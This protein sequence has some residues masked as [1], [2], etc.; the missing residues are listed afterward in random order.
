[1][2]TTYSALRI[3][4]KGSIEELHIEQL[5]FPEPQ[6]GFVLIKVECSTINPSD[7]LNILGHYPGGE[8]PLTPGL[9]GSGTVVKS[10]GGALADSLLNKRVTFIAP[11]SWAEYTITSATSVFPL[12]DSITFEQGASLNINP[13]TVAL[14]IE[15]VKQ[16]PSKAF[17]QNAASS[18]LAKQFIRWS[19]RLG[20]TSIN[21]VRR[22]EQVDLLKSFGAEHVFNTSEEGW[23]AK[24]KEI[25][26][27]FG[28]TIGFDAIGGKDTQ[29]LADV[30]GYKGVV[31]NYGL[32]SGKSCEMG[33]ASLQFQDKRLKGLW[34]SA[35]FK[36]TEYEKKLEASMSVQQNIDVLSTEYG[37]TVSLG[38][39]KTALA[40]YL[41][42]A[43]N[44][45]V[46]IRA[47]VE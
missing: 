3:N 6:E 14:F 28:V 11:G 12:L 32:L 23:K 31:Y 8:V 42:N 39:V 19:Q 20:I 26:T 17:V 27:Q 46:L 41:Q 4:Q 1:M 34:L 40:S 33:P 21:L 43:T 7:Y 10:G 47:I 30:L 5:P 16:R 38:N 35:W 45:K 29:D 15:K 13:L 22:Q 24:A 18:A 9:E 37:Q 25:A 44:N 36:V 2:S